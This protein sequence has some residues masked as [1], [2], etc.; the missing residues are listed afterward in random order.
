MADNAESMTMFPLENGV[1]FSGATTRLVQHFFNKGLEPVVE[2]HNK[3]KNIEPEELLE[4]ALWYAVD[5]TLESIVN[6]FSEAQEFFNPK[7]LSRETLQ[8]LDALN[9]SLEDFLQFDDNSKVSLNFGILVDAGENPSRD[10]KPDYGKVAK[11]LVIWGAKSHLGV[12]EGHLFG[13]AATTGVISQEAME[14]V[15]EFYN[16]QDGTKSQSLIMSYLDMEMGF[17]LQRLL[18]ETKNN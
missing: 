9:V 16:S 1:S 15:D 13:D 6:D 12:E 8:W 17:R 3:I 4:K 7:E 10:L 14:A 18:A 5:N 2:D 11:L